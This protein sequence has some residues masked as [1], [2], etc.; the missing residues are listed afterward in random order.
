MS[1]IFGVVASG[2]F[3][4]PDK[5]ALWIGSI[6]RLFEKSPEYRKDGIEEWRALPL[7]EI[8]PIPTPL[9]PERDPP[10]SI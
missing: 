5:C 7:R 8:E 2:I 9:A 3:V 6:N 10:P 4:A 1:M